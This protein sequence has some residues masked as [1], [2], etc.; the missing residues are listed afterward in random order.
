MFSYESLIGY[1]LTAAYLVVGILIGLTHKNESTQGSTID[2]LVAWAAFWPAL[3][4]YLAWDRIKN[5]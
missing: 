1:G 3:L 2:N 4:F 5:D